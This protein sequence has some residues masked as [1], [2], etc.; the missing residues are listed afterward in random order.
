MKVTV[1]YEALYA[2]KESS[3]KSFDIDSGE[4]TLMIGTDR[5]ERAQQAQSQS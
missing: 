1:R 2:R 3:S 5:H 4:L